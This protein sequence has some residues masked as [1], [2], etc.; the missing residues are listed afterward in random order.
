M[1]MYPPPLEGN[2]SDDHGNAMKPAIIQDCNR[3]M[4]YADESDRMT[5]YYCVGR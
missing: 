2:F 4:G 1:N 5:N 3:H